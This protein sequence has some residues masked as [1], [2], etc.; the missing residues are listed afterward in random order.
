M[1]IDID[2][3]FFRRSIYAQSR[4]EQELEL[5]VRPS[6]YRG[7]P[8]GVQLYAPDAYDLAALVIL[9]HNAVLF[10]AGAAETHV[11]A[12]AQIEGLRRNP[13]RSLHKA[14]GDLGLS[15]SSSMTSIARN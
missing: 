12:R 2:I 10:S 8:N 9:P 6:P 13:Y 15:V 14:L 7:N 5:L 3:V 1:D 4:A 11:I